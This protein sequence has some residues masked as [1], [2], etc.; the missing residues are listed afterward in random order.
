MCNIYFFIDVIQ[1]F[2]TERTPV[3]VQEGLLRVFTTAELTLRSD[4][5]EFSGKII[6]LRPKDLLYPG[7][8]VHGAE[9]TRIREI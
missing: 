9:G 1:L 8:L 6:L 5:P 7:L 4:I 2:F 3:Q